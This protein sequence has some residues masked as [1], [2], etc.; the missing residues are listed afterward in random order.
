MN[1]SSNTK[2]TEP[3]GDGYNDATRPYVF[4]PGEKVSLGLKRPWALALAVYVIGFF[5]LSFFIAV[6]TLGWGLL[7]IV[8]YYPLWLLIALALVVMT[9]IET[10]RLAKKAN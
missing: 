1:N 5:V 6:T 4:R 2:A 10:I 9:V 8:A 7:Y 3:T